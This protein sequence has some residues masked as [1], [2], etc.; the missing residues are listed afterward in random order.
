MMKIE[1]TSKFA[2]WAPIY[3]EA[4]EVVPKVVG[5]VLKMAL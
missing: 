2:A 4:V 3:S 5:V 1:N